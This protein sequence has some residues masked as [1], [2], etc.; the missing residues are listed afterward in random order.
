MMQTGIERLESYPLHLER[1]YFN[2]C[3][4]RRDARR[5]FTHRII[6]VSMAS[7]E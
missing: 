3:A 2:A 5:M 1:R 7:Y 6:T 4:N